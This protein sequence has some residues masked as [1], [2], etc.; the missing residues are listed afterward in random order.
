MV[1]RDQQEDIMSNR[2]NITNTTVVLWEGRAK[3]GREEDLRN[4]LR[5]AVT[6]SRNDT[7][8][9]DYEAHEIEGQAG[10]FIIYE[11]WTSKEA[12]DAHLNAPRMQELSPRFSEMIEGSIETGI[13]LLNP[14]RP[15]N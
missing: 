11:R 5:S 14:L 10:T 15:P 4:F 13:R 2:E 8:C 9:I 12:L 1:T 6:A 7:G 3:P